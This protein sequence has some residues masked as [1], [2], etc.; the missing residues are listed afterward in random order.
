M[1]NMHKFD[2][3]KTII[4]DLIK[5]KSQLSFCDFHVLIQLFINVFRI[6]SILLMN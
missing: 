2:E 6:Q 5:K 4:L 1:A 3:A